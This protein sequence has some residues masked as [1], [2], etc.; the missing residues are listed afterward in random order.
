MMQ[1]L[2]TGHLLGAS[3]RKQLVAQL[4]GIAAGILLC[5]P[6]YL[7]VTSA[8]ALGSDKLPAPSA[9]AWKA[10]AEVL[11]GG[12]DALPTKAVFGVLGGL[13]LGTAVPLLRAGLPRARPFLP[14][15]LAFGI[16]FLIPAYYS[17]CFLYGAVAFALW[18]RR[19]PAAAAALGFAVASGLIA[20]EGLMGIVT[21][22]LKLLGLG[23]LLTA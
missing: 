9:F 7:L 15:G 12:F 18:K 4:A 11:A 17:L 5:V 6:I 8:Y 3:P 1:D 14:S 23:P 2:K 20:G 13:L 22:A 19:S 21:A 10:M 16:A